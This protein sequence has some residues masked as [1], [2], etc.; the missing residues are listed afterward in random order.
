MLVR[1]A[2]VEDVLS[3][4]IIHNVI[5]DTA[6][7]GPENLAE[8]DHSRRNL[9]VMANLEILCHL[10]CLTKGVQIKYVSCWSLY[11]FIASLLALLESVETKGLEVHV[12]D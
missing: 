6:D 10:A 9:E 3:P 1:F 2:F 11:H 4:Y 12:S 8:E 7:N 5:K